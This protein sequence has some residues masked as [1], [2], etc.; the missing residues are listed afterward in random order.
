M[1]DA[2]TLLV[3]RWDNLSELLSWRSRESLVQEDGKAVAEKEHARD[4]GKGGV[5]GGSGPQSEG[6]G[7]FEF[8]VC[9]DSLQRWLSRAGLKVWLREADHIHCRL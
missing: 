7:G 1:R 8:A 3:S 4:S 5:P 2:Q 6:A 9:V